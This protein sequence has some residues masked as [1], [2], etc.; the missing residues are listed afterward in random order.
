MLLNV[1]LRVPEACV[2]HNGVT[3]AL[4]MTIAVQAVR[5]DPVMVVVAA[6]V[7]G[8]NDRSGE[9]TYYDRKYTII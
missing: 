1:R 6:V 4:E 9:G 2:Y 8:G 5:V 7:G 3:V